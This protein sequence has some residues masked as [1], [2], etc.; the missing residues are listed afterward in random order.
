MSGEMADDL[1]RRSHMSS[2]ASIDVGTGE[3][4][5]L[6]DTVEMRICMGKQVGK[7][8]LYL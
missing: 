4:W 3:R 8:D 7:L 2:L 1:F 5:G 6:V